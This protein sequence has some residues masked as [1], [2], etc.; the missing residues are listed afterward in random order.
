[1]IGA[2]Q[3]GRADANWESAKEAI[4][5]QMKGHQHRTRPG[6][7]CLREREPWRSGWL[8]VRGPMDGAS[9]MAALTTN[10]ETMRRASTRRRWL[11]VLTSSPPYTSSSPAR[12]DQAAAS[13]PV[14]LV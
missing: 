12:P 11:I 3:K 8:T 6:M 2:S 5:G 1:M 13:L 4:T 10:F 9:V 14:C 7:I